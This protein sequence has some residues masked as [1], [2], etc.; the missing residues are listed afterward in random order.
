MSTDVIGLF[1][2]EMFAQQVL[3]T[4]MNE[5]NEMEGENEPFFSVLLFSVYHAQLHVF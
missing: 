2:H 1:L 4:D 5:M 3:R